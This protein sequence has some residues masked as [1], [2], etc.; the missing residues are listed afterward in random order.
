MKSAKSL[1]TDGLAAEFY[2]QYPELVT[3][4]LLEVIAEAREKKE[5]LRTM[6]EVV[7]KSGKDPTSP[8]SYRPL[9]MLNA[10][11]KLTSHVLANRLLPY[12]PQLI[13]EDQSGFIPRR[14]T[15]RNIRRL[16]HVLQAL[17]SSKEEW[18]LA[19]LDIEQ[20]FD[21][22]RWEY[23]WQV[24]HKLGLGPRFEWVKLLHTNPTS[25]VRKGRYVSESMTLQR[26]MRQGC[27]LSL[28]LFDIAIEPLACHLGLVLKGWG[29]E[30][31]ELEHMV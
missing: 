26:G 16:A 28:L 12:F 21:S 17:E 13:H 29:I 30:I 9:T 20:A 5:F 22:V 3:D 23:I 31:G 2:K 25:R 27:P 24:L 7:P 19:F 6:R 11:L 10:D 1:G 18:T 8:N 4:R 15:L 14:N